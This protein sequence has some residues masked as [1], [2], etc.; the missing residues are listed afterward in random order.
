MTVLWNSALERGG[1]RVLWCFRTGCWREEGTKCDSVWEQ[2]AGERREQCD[3]V[4]EQAAGREG[5]VT[6]FGN[7]VLERGG[8]TV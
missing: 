2:V 5:S 8:D 6:V 1:N 7:R 3:G 4:W